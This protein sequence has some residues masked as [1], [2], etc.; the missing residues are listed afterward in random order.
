[1]TWS[2]ACL[3]LLAAGH[4][5]LVICGAT[6]HGFDADK[7]PLPAAMSTYSAVSGANSGYGFFAPGVGAER[8]LTCVF[9][10]KAG[11]TWT[12]MLDMR[13][14]GQEVNVR[15][16]PLLLMFSQEELRDAM[17][18][19]VA[20]KML[21]EHPEAEQVLIRIEMHFVPTMDEY[22]AGARPEWVVG[23]EATF[24]RDDTE[25]LEERK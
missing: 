16:L 10:D 4:L 17:A 8:R 14:Q 15:A 23:Y 5:S 6:H 18:A 22:R 12:R 19:S 20:A 24:T 9:T 21:G 2:H 1:M 3:S 13:S 25:S 7:G 11:H